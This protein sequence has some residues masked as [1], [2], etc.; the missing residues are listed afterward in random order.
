MGG[1]LAVGIS[2][3]W[4]AL[5]F[6]GDGLTALVLPSV[7]GDR[8][9]AATTVGLI[10]F[11]GLGL[12]VLVQPFAGRLSDASRDRVDRRRFLAVAS[13]PA[14]VALALLATVQGVPAIAG[15]Y[16]LAMVAGS[17][18]QAGQQTLIPEH[19]PGAR[20]GR[21]ASLK[22]AFDIGGALVAFLLLGAALELGGVSAAMA[23]TAVVLTGSL[24]ILWW[25]VPAGVRR[26]DRPASTGQTLASARFWQLISA[27]FLF[28]FGIYV[29]GRFLLLLVEDRL[30]IPPERAAAETGGL[31]AVFTLT[32]AGVALAL[33]PAVDRVG[34]RS[35]MIAGA[36]TAAIGTGLF[37][38]PAGLIGAVVAGILMSIG[39]AAFTT[40]NWAALTGSTTATDAGRLMGMAN[41]GTGGA[42][43]CAGLLGPSIDA[44]G[45]TPALVV[46]T[47]SILVSL[48]PIARPQRSTLPERSVA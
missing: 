37:L 35:L 6:L 4:V 5:A 21:A 39:T 30:G 42:A 34:R 41:V 10:S 8:G 33:G 20:Q 32:T 23:V 16:L 44:F 31:L 11:M 22:T 48:A 27:R 38:V 25:C 24:I 29:V 36:L 14:F 9:D 7:F 26:T 2:V 19:V 15:A 1:R 47:V 28:L 43:A 45:F 46:A 3:V 13:V 18:I 17:A 40:A 12:A